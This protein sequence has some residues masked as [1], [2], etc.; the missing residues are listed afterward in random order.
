[1][2]FFA[3]NFAQD[4]ALEGAADYART[5]DSIQQQ[6]AAYRGERLKIA[7][8]AVT[9]LYASSRTLIAWTLSSAVLALLVVLPLGLVIM[10]GV[11]VR[12][13]SITEAM[14]RLAQHD[15]SVE[16]DSRTDGDEV[17]EMARA[18]TVFKANALELLQRKAQLE[19]VNL[20]L[21]VALNNMM[22]GLCM[23]DADARI[24]V[25]NAA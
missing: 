1:M 17:G 22:H 2:I 20:Q 19:Q 11:L 25:V 5:A 14:R 8:S 21:D 4:K 3:E 15:T 23:F 16:V 18:V 24:I 6:I 13:G 9:Q 12:L 10:R 7:D